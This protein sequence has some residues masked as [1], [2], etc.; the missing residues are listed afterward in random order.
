M[1]IEDTPQPICQP[2]I[3]FDYPSWLRYQDLSHGIVRV[4]ETI[5]ELSSNRILGEINQIK[6][7]QRPE[8]TL[9][10]SSPGGGAYY[11]FAIYDAL[12]VLSKSGTKIKAIVEGWAASAASMII[13]QAADI[14]L[15][16]ASARFL[17]HECRRWVFFAIE[18]TTDL[19]DEVK[20]M[21]AITSRIL[22]ILS[23]RCGKTKS[24]VRKK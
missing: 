3:K 5:R 6:R 16:H 21:D 8:M 14:R 15:S 12:R 24:E 10:I 11:A 13:L 1:K 9:I 23:K 2:E 17:L 4:D 19:K 18:R 22:D 7:Q 20:E